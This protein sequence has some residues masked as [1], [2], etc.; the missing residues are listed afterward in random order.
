VKPPKT[1]EEIRTSRP[2]TPERR[3]RVAANREALLAEI[4]LHALRERRG[5]TQTALAEAM[6]LS[7][8]R[9]ST[10]E[11]AGEDLRVSTLERY[12]EALGGK[13]RVVAVFDDEEIVVG[14]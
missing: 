14:R 13:L 3:A 11:N 6:L 5:V 12:I 8:P 4:E 10:I 9:V 1:L 7:R 2:D